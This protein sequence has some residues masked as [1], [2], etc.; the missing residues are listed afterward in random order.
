MLSEY[1]GFYGPRENILVKQF[2]SLFFNY[3]CIYD[4][5]QQSNSLQDP[6]T[7]NKPNTSNS[8]VRNARSWRIVLYCFLC[9][10]H[11]EKLHLYWHFPLPFEYFSPRLP[12]GKIIFY[13]LTPPNDTALPINNFDW[14]HILWY[15]Y[16]Y[17]TTISTKK[18]QIPIT[19][20]M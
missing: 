14:S 11:L 2:H 19:I 20:Y 1:C 10:L 7:L 6:S 18:T 8:H 12:R 9:Y 15:T 13:I 17:P 5:W 16:V 3:V 4:E